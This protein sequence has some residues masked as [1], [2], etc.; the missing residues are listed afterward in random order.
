MSIARVYSHPSRKE[1]TCEKC[2]QP[3]PKGDTYL[4]YKV[5]FRSGY[6]HRRH[7]GCR[8]RNSELESSML[9]EAYAAVEGAEDAISSAEV[10]EDFTAALEEAASGIREVAE[11]YREAAE[12]MGGAGYENEERADAL[13]SAADELESVDFDDNT[14]DCEVCEGSGKVKCETCDGTGEDDSA[15]PV[16]ADG[17]EVTDAE[18]CAVCDGTGEVDCEEEGCEG[19]QVFSADAAREAAQ[20]ALDAIEWP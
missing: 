7:V 10:A 6:T 1:Y 17:D 15:D 9:S 16:E 2:R 20:E 8:P 3:I 11:Q 4:S 18:S 13:E 14:E 12:A 5:G 19:G